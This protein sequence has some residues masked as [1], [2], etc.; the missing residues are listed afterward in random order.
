MKLLP[1]VVY[2]AITQ[3][4]SK[5]FRRKC[6]MQC[7]NLA[8]K[9]FPSFSAANLN[10]HKKKNWNNKFRD[11]VIS[12]INNIVGIHSLMILLLILFISDWALFLLHIFYTLVVQQ[13]IMPMIWDDI[14]FHA[15]CSCLL[16]LFIS[17]LLYLAYCMV[18]RCLNHCAFILCNYH[19]VI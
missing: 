3:L 11:T 13:N 1:F 9:C 17:S 6:R 10:F 16:Y 7:N 12:V 5:Y 4:G 19:G 15:L 18:I 14:C 2:S 8:M